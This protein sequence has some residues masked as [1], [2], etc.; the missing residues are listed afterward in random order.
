MKKKKTEENPGVRKKEERS[1]CL[2]PEKTAIRWKNDGSK[3]QKS[4]KK[5]KNTK[6]VRIFCLHTEEKKTQNAKT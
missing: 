5:T 1:N 2:N 3:T 4:K 6:G